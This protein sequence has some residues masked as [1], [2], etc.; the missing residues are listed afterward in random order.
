MQWGKERSD[1]WLIS[2]ILSFC[3]SLLVV[4]PIK[5]FAITAIITCILRKPQ[6]EEESLIDSGDPLYNAIVNKDEE[7]LHDNQQV[8]R[9]SQINVREILESRRAKLTTLNPI[10]PEELERQRVE[11][12][13]VIKMKEILYEGLSYLVFLIIVLFLAHQSRSKN[14]NLI[15]QDLQNTF[16]ENSDMAFGDIQSK[17]DFWA[18]MDSVFMPGLYAPRWYNDGSLSWREKLTISNRAAIRVTLLI[19]SV[20]VFFFKKN[21]I[22]I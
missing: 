11:R 16:L 17:E 3:Q 4:D 22:I 2:M 15:Y 6:D 20:F 10:D 5:V 9:I 21:T 8:A 12:K 1:A 14:A 7:Y 18:Y 19:R 13:K